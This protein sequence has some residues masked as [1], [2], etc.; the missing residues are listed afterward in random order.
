MPQTLL[1]MKRTRLANILN[2]DYFPK[3]GRA[4]D[5]GCHDG[6][7]SKELLARGFEVDAVDIKPVCEIIDEKFHFFHANI[8]N[9]TINNATYSVILAYY[10]LPF[11]R[12]KQLIQSKI[13]EIRQGL[14]ENGIAVITLFGTEHEWYKTGIG[15]HAFY[16][17][18]EA[19]VVIGDYIDIETNE[20]MSKQWWGQKYTGS[21]GILLSK[22]KLVQSVYF[23]QEKKRLII[24]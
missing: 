19:K 2:K 3:P 12:D 23:T 4:L 11:L 21:H 6:R 22:S 1:F 8:E 10:V 14:V 24:R 20:G 15:K 13:N 18:D 17:L 5:I 16:T 9:Y 7:E